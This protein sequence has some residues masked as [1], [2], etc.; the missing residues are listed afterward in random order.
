[1][2]SLAKTPSIAVCHGTGPSL[3]LGLGSPRARYI[4]APL[5]ALAA[6][7]GC[8]A[9][10]DQQMTLL[11]D[12]QRAYA[13][14]QYT[15]A[16]RQL[17]RFVNDVPSR[18]ETAQALYVRALSHTKLQHRGPAYT[19]LQ[20]ALDLP[21][22]NETQWRVHALLGSLYFDDGHWETAHRH[23]AAAAAGMPAAP[24]LDMVLYRH[25]Q[26]LERLGRWSEARSAFNRAARQFPNTECGRLAR[27]R[28]ELQ[29]SCFAIQCGSFGDQANAGKLAARLQASG[30]SAWVRQ[31]PGRG[32]FVV[33][34]GR[35]PTYA[36]AKQ[37]LGQVRG[38]VSDAVI[39]P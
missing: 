1:M 5:V 32:R 30:L 35:Y 17:T 14:G 23:Y 8:N 37:A 21:A 28:L 19:D 26:C 25:G 24:P 13:Q 12:G 3:A 38:Q 27:R 18:G 7:A 33:L 6:L 2:S 15:L 22:N 4:T 11:A 16:V 10:T 36:D 20:R 29:A 31:D 39:W 9:V 34:V